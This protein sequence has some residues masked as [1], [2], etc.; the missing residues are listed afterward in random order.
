MN[1]EKMSRRRF[2]GVGTGVVAAAALTPTSALGSTQSEAA[3]TADP[4]CGPVPGGLLPRER[5]GIQLYTI[6][7]QV[8]SLGFAKVFEAL[9][10][11][12]YKEVEFA[13]YTQGSVGPITLEQ[14]RQLLDDNGLRAAGSHASLT[15]ANVQ[16]KLDEAQILGMPTIGNPTTSSSGG[17][18]VAGWQAAAATYNQ[19]GEACATRGLRFYLHN[20]SA[21]FNFPQDQPLGPTRIYD[22]LLERTD[23]AKVFFEMDI[24][25]AFVGQYRYGRSPFP[26]F[27]PLDYVTA[28][29]DRFPLF[30]VKDGRPSQ[31]AA[32]GYS[33]VDVGQGVID[34]QNFFT[35]LDGGDRHGYLM[36]HDGAASGTKGSLGSALASYSWMRYGLVKP[37]AGTLPL[38]GAGR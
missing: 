14:I 9:A 35:T 18:T 28:Q 10:E 22:I 4:D 13:G 11:M 12:G 5:I 33:M 32:D 36:E 17:N 2:L 34:F 26:T 38:E 8:S 27:N 24:Y 29:K 31:T 19:I 16:Q 20:H 25:W 15:T 37:A 1:K 21:E 7:D 30:H 3:S 6:R 23:P